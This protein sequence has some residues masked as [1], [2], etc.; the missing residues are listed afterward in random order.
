MEVIKLSESEMLQ[1]SETLSNVYNQAMHQQ[2]NL[3]ERIQNSI[4]SQKNPLI[5]VVVDH[6]QII[7]FVYGF[8]FKKENW[9]AQQVS[10]ELPKEI[11]W[12]EARFEL[13]ELM[14]LPEYQNQGVGSRLMEDLLKQTDF[15]GILLSTARNK[16]DRAVA[17][18][19]KWGF[20][21][22]L[23]PFYYSYDKKQENPVILFYL[24]NK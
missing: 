13:N 18:Y 10:H 21:P 14:V 8:D 17:F 9:W 19:K 1:Y 16:N 23:E 11:D 2:V 15:I 12:F 4:E 5:F 22:L 7:G 20:Q 3:L 24:H 6:G